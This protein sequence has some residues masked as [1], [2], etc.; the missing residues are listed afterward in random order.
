MF[1]PY[2]H[3]F[4]PWSELGL[5]KF[6]VVALLTIDFKMPD[7]LSQ[8][9]Q[10]DKE[11]EQKTPPIN[12]QH[13]PP[14]ASQSHSPSHPSPSPP[15]PRPAY[16]SPRPN[17]AY[18]YT[19]SRPRRLSQQHNPYARVGT[20]CSRRPSSCAAPQHRPCGSRRRRFRRA[21]RCWMRARCRLRGCRIGLRP[22]C[23]E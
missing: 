4:V 2:K 15:P 19:D 11:T 10:G 7:S 13:T 22:L 1:L 14:S 23:C 5:C 17:P 9:L 18:N 12:Q 8:T 20:N 21:W 3:F 6:L 16:T